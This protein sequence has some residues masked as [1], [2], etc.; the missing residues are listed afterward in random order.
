MSNMAS[1]YDISKL[2]LGQIVA[3]AACILTT[4][5]LYISGNSRSLVA[6]AT[7]TLAYGLMMF[8]SSYVEEEQHFWYWATTAWMA[9]LVLKSRPRYSP[10][11]FRLITDTETQRPRIC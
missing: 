11:A 7:I 3:A 1:N 4:T 8:A 2:V 6:F 9:S 10:P 5:A